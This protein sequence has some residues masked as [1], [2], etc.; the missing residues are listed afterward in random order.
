MNQNILLPDNNYKP[1][2]KI[3]EEEKRDKRVTRQK[4]DQMQ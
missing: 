4:T 2:R 3:A 1:Q